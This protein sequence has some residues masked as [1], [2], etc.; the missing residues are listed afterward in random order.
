MTENCTDKNDIKKP[1]HQNLLIMLPL[2]VY[3]FSIISFIFKEIEFQN[4]QNINDYNNLGIILQKLIVLP[5]ENFDL[6][7]KYKNDPTLSSEVSGSLRIENGLLLNQANTILKR[8]P[9]KFVT[10][11]DYYIVGHFYFLNQQYPES[12]NMLN[13]AISYREPL[14]IVIR[15]MLVKSIAL[16]FIDYHKG[17]EYFG[18]TIEYLKIIGHENKTLDYC[19]P[20]ITYAETRWTNLEIMLGHY[21]K[22]QKHLNIAKSYYAKINKFSGQQD[23]LKP[24]LI[25]LQ[26]LINKID[27]NN[28]QINQS[29]LKKLKKIF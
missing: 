7:Q 25:F 18:Q 11:Y 13:K 2:I 20:Q 21:E 3:I 10:P 9:P 22:A 24:T 29:Q 6:M 4:E 23:S 26:D 15:S 5:R 12:I 1:W 8:I 28:F 16:A 14:E 19:Y 27:D 17:N